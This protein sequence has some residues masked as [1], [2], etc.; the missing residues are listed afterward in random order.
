MKD[1]VIPSR[2]IRRELLAA[3]ACFLTSFLVNVG[4]V[5]AYHKN[6]TEIFTQ[7]GYVVVI[8]VFFYVILWVIRILI[9]IIKKIIN[10]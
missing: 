2:T 9:L 3:L 1:I 4:A 10:R 5:I 6:W 7:I 8:S